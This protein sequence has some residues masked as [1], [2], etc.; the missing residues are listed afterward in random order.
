[1]ADYDITGLTP[2]EMAG[3]LLDAAH[4]GDMDDARRIRDIIMAT[5][6]PPRAY[7][8]N[9]YIPALGGTPRP[10]TSPHTIADPDKRKRAEKVCAAIESA[11]IVGT[12]QA[13]LDAARDL[14][15][16]GESWRAVA[17]RILAEDL[18]L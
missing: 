4:A 12:R 16:L 13:H 2:L 9:V 10:I 11:C 18:T 3:A 14:D 5:P 17:L 6:E 1:M 8:D 7:T 15:A